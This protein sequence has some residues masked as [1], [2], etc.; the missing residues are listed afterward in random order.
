MILIQD[1][2][3]L[4]VTSFLHS[5][6]DLYTQTTHTI[7]EAELEEEKAAGAR[8]AASQKKGQTKTAKHP[9]RKQFM[10]VVI[11]NSSPAQDKQV[12]AGMT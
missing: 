10:N 5:S 12:E 9:K 4:R 1:S 3:C 2:P 7:A 11:G 6:S 8:A